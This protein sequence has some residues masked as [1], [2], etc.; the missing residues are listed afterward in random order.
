[1]TT[2]FAPHEMPGWPRLMP[3]Q[4]AAAYM[5]VSAT[6]FDRLHCDIEPVPLDNRNKVWDRQDLDAK[7]DR[8]KSDAGSV[9]DDFDAEIEAM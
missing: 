6:T 7:I 4:L 5:G 8:M 1:M 9:D 2:R 3:R